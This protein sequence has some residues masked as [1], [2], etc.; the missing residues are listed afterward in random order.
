MMC[1]PGAGHET[2][3]SGQ[4][5]VQSTPRP[6][7]HYSRRERGWGG[8]AWTDPIPTYP[9]MQGSGFIGWDWRSW[10]TVENVRTGEVFVIRPDRD[11]GWAEIRDA[12]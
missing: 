1:D 10:S 8:R 3:E 11:G 7:G 2:P 9:R 4:E 5:T 12:S 6:W